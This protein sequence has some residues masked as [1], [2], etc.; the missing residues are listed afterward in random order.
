MFDLNRLK[1]FEK[2]W[3]D[4][5]NVCVYIVHLC[6]YTQQQSWSKKKRWWKQKECNCKQI[7]LINANNLINEQRRIKK[8]KMIIEQ[9]NE[10]GVGEKNSTWKEKKNSISIN[11]IMNFGTKHFI[12]DF[13]VQW[14]T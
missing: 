11:R 1:E 4:G 14:I 9:R 6:K 12:Y 7:M 10:F 13:N 5:Y 2:L 8:K 3:N